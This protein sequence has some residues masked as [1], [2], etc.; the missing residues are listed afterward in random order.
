MTEIFRK[1]KLKCK[2]CDSY[3]VYYN[4]TTKQI[5]ILCNGCGNAESLKLDVVKDSKGEK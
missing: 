4:G 3:E 1:F 5:N 2:V